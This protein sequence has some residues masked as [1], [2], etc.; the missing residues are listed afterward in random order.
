METGGAYVFRNEPSA[1]PARL[2][3]F[4]MHEHVRI[5]EPETV[6]AWREEWC[7]RA[8]EFLSSLGLDV[9]LQPASDPFFGRSGRILASSQLQQELKL[10]IVASISGPRP[11]AIA[12]LNYHQDHFASRFGLETSDGAVAHSACVGFGEERIVLALLRSARP[13]PGTWPTEVRERLWA[14]A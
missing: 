4:H 8:L 2:Q 12:S 13:R 11:T 9:Q 7:G 3:A 1:D 5:A 10:E 6:S 14:E